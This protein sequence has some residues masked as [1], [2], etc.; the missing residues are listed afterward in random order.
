VTTTIAIIGAGAMG[1]VVARRLVSHGARVITLL[2]GRREHTAARARE[3]G[4]IAA[5]PADIASA[6]LVL[7]IVPPAE[8]VGVAASLA[9]PLRAGR[10]KPAF[11]DCNATSPSTMQEVAAALTESGCDVLDGA[12]IGPP[13]VPGRDGPTFYVSGDPHGRTELLSRF[14]LKLRRIDGPPGAASALKMCYAGINKG[15]IALGTAML[16][17]AARSGSAES[18]RQELEESTPQVL[19]R[20][21][22]GIPDMYPK[23][24]RWVAE[25]RE[26]AGFLG[27]DDP[28]APMLEAAAA[29]FARMAADHD[30]DGTL[31]AALNRVLGADGEAAPR[32]ALP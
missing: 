8:A 25:M 21:G 16:L 1:S 29:V 6:E 10:A 2:E 24:Y 5:A 15:L 32:R 11:V 20:L 3:A 26:I 7:S 31:A 14:G 23:A 9:A 4:M 28:A 17:A 19:A 12:I 18:L 13:P 22:R 27:P 30:G